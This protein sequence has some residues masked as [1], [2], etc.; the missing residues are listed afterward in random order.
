[1]WNL[2]RPVSGLFGQ[3]LGVCIDCLFILKSTVYCDEMRRGS[4]SSMEQVSLRYLGLLGLRSSRL[5][6]SRHQN[7]SCGVH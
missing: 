1:M 2:L 4:A 6:F 5:L 7:N 3:L